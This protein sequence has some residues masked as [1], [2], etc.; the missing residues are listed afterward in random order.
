MVKVVHKKLFCAHWSLRPLRCSPLIL[1]LPKSG[2]D[3]TVLWWNERLLQS[4]VF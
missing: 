2:I 1:Q 4:Q 3:F